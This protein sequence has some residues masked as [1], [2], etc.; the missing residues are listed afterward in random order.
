[1][2]VLCSFIG[3]AIFPA[4]GIV[5]G[6]VAKIYEPDPKT[7]DEEREALVKEFA[8]F[9]FSLALCLFILGWMQFT[10]LQAAS[11]RLSFNLRAKYLSALMRQE[12]KYF[13]KQ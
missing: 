2:G 10:C 8:I 5:L 6:Y 3:G 13:E 7:T 4:Y 12:I 9:A 11:E 1:M